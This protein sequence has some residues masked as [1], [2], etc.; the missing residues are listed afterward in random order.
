MP[1]LARKLPRCRLSLSSATRDRDTC[2]TCDKSAA[3]GRPLRPSPGAL[4]TLASSTTHLYEGLAEHP[5]GDIAGR[6]ALRVLLHA[7]RLLRGGGGGGGGA[8]HGS[9][10]RGVVGACLERGKRLARP[11]G[12]VRGR[13]GGVA[14]AVRVCSVRRRRALVRR[15]LGVAGPPR[16]A[17][18]GLRNGQRAP[19]IGPTPGR[20]AVVHGRLRGEVKVTGAGARWLGGVAVGYAGAGVFVGQRRGAEGQAAGQGHA[21][22][23]ARLVG[24]EAGLSP[25]RVAAGAVPDQRV[26]GGCRGRRGRRRRGRVGGGA[27]HVLRESLHR[28]RVP[29]PGGRVDDVARAVVVH[30]KVEVAAG[31]SPDVDA[32]RLE[33]T[34]RRRG[35]SKRWRR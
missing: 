19:R 1:H 33:A 11:D 18:G 2:H 13:R 23:G 16:F 26:A 21:G 12:H 5:A 20:R 9:Q 7:L 14:E 25:S 32:V 8:R 35:W 17:L 28:H 29:Q 30:Q 22:L 10:E 15:G 31:L 34:L 3:S 24:G 4:T 27:E 6:C